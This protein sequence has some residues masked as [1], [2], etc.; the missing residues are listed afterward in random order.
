MIHV[1]RTERLPDRYALRREQRLLGSVTLGPRMSGGTFQVDGIA[2]EVRADTVRGSYDLLAADGSVLATAERVHRRHWSVRTADGTSPFRRGGL[3]RAESLTDADGHELGRITRSGRR[4]A[5]AVVDLPGLD[6]TVQAFALTL[7]LMRRRRRR[8][9]ATR[10]T[11][12]SVV[13]R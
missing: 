10:T 8:R 6:V 12:V 1:D 11:A 9:I 5:G 2:Y 4:S 13:G 7:A 3:A